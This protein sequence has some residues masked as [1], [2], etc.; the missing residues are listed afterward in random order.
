MTGSSRYMDVGTRR[1]ALSLRIGVA[2]AIAVVIVP[3]V[4][5]AQSKSIAVDWSDPEIK[6]YVAQQKRNPRAAAQQIFDPRLTRLK[7]PVIGLVG[8]PASVKRSF[9]VAPRAKPDVVM[10]P[11]NPVWYS[12]TYEYG[13]DVK[14]TIEADLR[15]QHRLG[16]QAKVYKDE[17][18]NDPDTAIS[19]FDSTS[20]VGMTGAIAEF[21]IYKFG[22]IPYVVTVE[23]TEKTKAT[24]QDTKALAQDKRLLKIISA[25]PP[26]N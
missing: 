22:N 20:E 21:K 8:T 12:I 15:V 18:G 19:V 24:C 7:L 11:D 4:A 6:R 26:E 17:K 16:P 3:G 1:V 25:R 9:S 5:L 10:D 2:A 13:P 14:V 23:C